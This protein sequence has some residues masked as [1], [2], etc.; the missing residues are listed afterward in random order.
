MIFWAV[1][2]GFFGGGGGGVCW[3]GLSFGS[4][5]IPKRGYCLFVLISAPGE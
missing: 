2:E 5:I 3:G 4:N 1:E